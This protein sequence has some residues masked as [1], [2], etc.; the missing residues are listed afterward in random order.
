MAASTAQPMYAGVTGIPRHFRN[1]GNDK[2]GQRTNR[3]KSPY[4]APQN[5][6]YEGRT[7]M[8]SFYTRTRGNEC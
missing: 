1:H 3:R 8:A 2:A 5:S 7:T 4:S 6:E